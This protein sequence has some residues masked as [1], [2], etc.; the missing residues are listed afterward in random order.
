MFQTLGALVKGICVLDKKPSISYLVPVC[1]AHLQS[2]VK[3]TY[4]NFYCL[5]CLKPSDSL[6]IGDLK[7]LPTSGLCHRCDELNCGFYSF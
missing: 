6:I 4:P 1:S 2:T 3:V 5:G 7:S